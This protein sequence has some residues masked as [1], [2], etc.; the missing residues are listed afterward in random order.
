MGGVLVRDLPDDVHRLLKER[1]AGNRR[2][3]SAEVTTLLEQALGG[4]PRPAPPGIVGPGGRKM[5]HIRICLAQEVESGSN[6]FGAFRLRPESFPE[7]GL[8]DVDTSATFV[9]RELAFPF[10]IAS[11]SGGIGGENRF[12]HR[13]AAAAQDA[14]CGLALGSMR[15]AVED[16][17]LVP[18]YDVRSLA[19]DVPVLGN[20]SAW[21]LRDRGF[22]DRVHELLLELDLDGL[23]IHVNPAHELVQPEGE[24]DFAG[25]LEAVCMFAQGCAR[26]VFL[27]EVGAGLSTAHLHRL[28]DVSIAGIDV[29]GGG[30]TD[31]AKVE[32]LRTEDPVARRLGAELHRLYRPTAHLLKS[33]AHESATLIASGGLRTA[34]DMA[35]A[36]ALGAD[37][38]SCARPVLQA[39]WGEPDELHALLRYYHQGLKSIMLLCGCRRVN[40]L[41]QSLMT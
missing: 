8:D 41:K 2:S 33:V 17:A 30:G 21:Q 7:M 40:E 11:M 28:L 18:E 37:L 26:P 5:E 19:P 36:L 16:R 14:G 20:I 10:V 6:G 13:L 23:F 31:F 34:H 24:R 3:L 4:E 35:L 9:G 38:V 15:P 27:K 22:A 29:A 12:N 25:A 32:S 39:A 1:A